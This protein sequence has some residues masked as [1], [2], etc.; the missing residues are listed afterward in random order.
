MCGAAG[1]YNGTWHGCRI[2]DKL[3]H[4][5]CLEQKGH[6]SDELDARALEESESEIGWS[7]PDCV[8]LLVSKVRELFQMIKWNLLGF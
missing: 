8:S 5:L 6:L 7:C 1:S 3:Y 2:C 4:H